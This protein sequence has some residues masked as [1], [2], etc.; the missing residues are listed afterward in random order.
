MCGLYQL[1][2]YCPIVLGYTV[3][4]YY[5]KVHTP[6]NAHFIKIDEVLKFALKS[7]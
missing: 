4:M 5:N 1:V 6:T 2:L 7:L 3:I